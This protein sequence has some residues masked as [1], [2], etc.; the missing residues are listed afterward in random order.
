MVKVL[1]SFRGGPL[2]ASTLTGSRKLP[3]KKAKVSPI[4]HRMR[5]KGKQCMNQAKGENYENVRS[6][7]GRGN[8]NRKGERLTI[9]EDASSS[10]LAAA[11]KGPTRKFDKASLTTVR[12]RKRKQQQLP[13]SQLHTCII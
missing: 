13:R 11:S 10:S 2:P 3:G 7:Q 1:L 8:Q 5:E 4:P 6:S 12:G 9:S